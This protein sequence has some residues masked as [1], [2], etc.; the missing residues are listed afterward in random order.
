MIKLNG[1]HGTSDHPIR[2]QSY[3]G[4]EVIITGAQKP[5]LKWVRHEGNIWKTKIYD[6]PAQLFLDGEM[7]TGARY[8]NITKNWHEYDESNG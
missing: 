8:P 3:Q 5:K 1:R 2:I 6:R 4:E 7:L